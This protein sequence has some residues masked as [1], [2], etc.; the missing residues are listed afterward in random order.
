VTE[1]S[2][3]YENQAAAEVGSKLL[4][5]VICRGWGGAGVGVDA[6]GLAGVFPA[7]GLCDGAGVGGG[8]S[9]VGR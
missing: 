8:A 6:T 4:W 1:F 2:R 3:L 9:G 7:A 5:V